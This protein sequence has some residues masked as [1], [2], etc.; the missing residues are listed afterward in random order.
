MKRKSPG[1][2]DLLE[3]FFT[4]YMPNSAGLSANTIKSYKYAFRLL[5]EYLYANKSVD[6][7]GVK[8]KTLN[9]DTVNGFLDW[10]EQERGLFNRNSQSV[11]DRVV[12]VRDLRTKPKHR[13]RN[14]R[15]CYWQDTGKNAVGGSAHDVSARRNSDI[16]MNCRTKLPL[17]VCA[18]AFY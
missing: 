10:L 14:I 18:T 16:A 8:F 15:E 2:L 1:F 3:V 5:M 13:C 9:F 6:S 4:E 11:A 17:S 7:G 12:V